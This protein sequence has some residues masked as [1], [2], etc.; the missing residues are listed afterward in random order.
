[1]TENGVIE[2]SP[3]YILTNKVIMLDDENERL[4]TILK[5]MM[6]NVWGGF[7]EWLWLHQEKMCHG[8]WE[9][10]PHCYLTRNENTGE[11]E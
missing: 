2:Q 8:L 5:K 6:Q 10:C 4:H 9:S 3:I 11:E 1:M 7:D